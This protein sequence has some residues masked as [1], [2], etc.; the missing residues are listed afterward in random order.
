MEPKYRYSESAVKPEVIQMDGD[1]VYLRN[2]V[3]E[4]IREDD[5]GNKTTYWS[6]QEAVLT[7]DEFNIY[8]SII[9]SKNAINSV[10]VPDNI[11]QLVAGQEVADSN[12]LTVMEAVA[13]LYDTIATMMA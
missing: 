9:A 7:Q 2:G 5:Q 11:S 8:A 1:T 4:I 6:Y 3:A 13:E 10:G 12:Q